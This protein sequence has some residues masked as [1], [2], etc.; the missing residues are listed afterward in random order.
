MK[1]PN[2]PMSA[3]QAFLLLTGTFA[4]AL[5]IFVAVYAVLP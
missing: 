5:T 3:M 2:E 1:S 4:V